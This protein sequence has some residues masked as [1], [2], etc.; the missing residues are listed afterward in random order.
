MV[1]K[2]TSPLTKFIRT[3][4]GILVIAANGV[5]I[6][7]PLAGSLPWGTSVKYMAILNGITVVSRS[8]LKG[9]ASLSP[10][11]GAPTFPAG[12]PPALENEDE[13]TQVAADLNY[14]EGPPETGSDVLMGDGTPADQIVAAGSPVVGGQQL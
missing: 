13:A 9:I 5:L 3:T 4:E 1:P 6:I 14:E 11:L 10:A 8:V 2:L 12:L 7:V